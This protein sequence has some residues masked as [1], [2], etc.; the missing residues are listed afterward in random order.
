[1][2]PDD[3]SQK[4]YPTGDTHEKDEEMKADPPKSWSQDLLD[5]ADVMAK[6]SSVLDSPFRRSARQKGM[7]KGFKA[8]VCAKK[9]CLGCSM[10]PPTLSSSTIKNI[11]TSLCMIDPDVLSDEA[12]NLIG[13]KKQKIAPSPSGKKQ[14]KKQSPSDNVRKDDKKPKK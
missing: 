14:Q 13:N 6:Y 8:S 2:K 9:G 10:N 5:R 7:H 12:L 11:G 4:I 1:M 3:L